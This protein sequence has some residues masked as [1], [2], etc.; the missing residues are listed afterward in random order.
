MIIQG[1]CLQDVIV[2]STGVFKFDSQ[3][4]LLH[5]SCEL[6]E[7]ID[8]AGFEGALMVLGEDRNAIGKS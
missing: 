2:R 7:L 1:C 5:K 3:E 6:S 8:R 4:G